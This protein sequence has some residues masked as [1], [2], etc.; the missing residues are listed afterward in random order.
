MTTKACRVRVT[1]PL[2]KY[3]AGFDAALKVQ[4]YKEY[5]RV[6]QLQRLARL[7]RWMQADEVDARAL[8]APVVSGFLAG[9]SAGLARVRPFGP[10]IEFLIGQRLIEEVV[11]SPI[12][13]ASVGL[14]E[15]YHQMLADDRGLSTE[16]L[17][18]YDRTA[19]LFLHAVGGVEAVGAL[20]TAAVTRFL[21]E[22]TV[23]KSVAW[24]KAMVF[25]L[26]SLLRFL[27]AEGLIDRRLDLAVPSVGG[28]RK[29][30]LPKA[31][32]VGDV[33]RMLANCDRRK[34][35]GRRDFAILLLLWRLGL[36]AREVSALNL[37]DIDWREGEMVV[38][39][40]GNRH[41]RL[42]LPVDVGD[43]IAGYL[44]RGRPPVQSRAVFLTMSAPIRTLSPDGVRA[45]VRYACRRAGLAPFGSHR[46]R[47]TTATQLLSEG[48]SLE[49]IAQ[50]LRHEN[51]DTTS[52]YAKVDDRALTEVARPWPGR[53][54]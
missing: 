4:G 15:R 1:G 52:I 31:V 5:S 51:L 3:A 6:S 36:R 50:V 18:V 32:A 48:S 43:G 33:E 24:S 34:A 21:L 54:A 11:A 35:V 9:D 17:K 42:P 19:A 45:V 27:F 14:L 16:S 46:L 53:L 37:G 2:A 26:R 20:D 39:G 13:D 44:R 47:H 29:S 49:E 25:G 38:R 12:V 10:L 8:T 40:K 28:W 30:T 7:S 22:A 23:G 41:D